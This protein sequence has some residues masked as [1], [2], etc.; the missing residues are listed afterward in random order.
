MACFPL[1]LCLSYTL[2]LTKKNKNNNNTSLI[3]KIQLPSLGNSPEWSHL[4]LW[5]ELH[6]WTLCLN[7]LFC[8]VQFSC[9]VV[10][11][12]LQPHGLQHT[13]LPC[14][15]PNSRSLLKHMSIESVITS[16]HLTVSSPSLP[17]FNLSQHQG[18]FQWVSSLHQVAKV[19]QLQL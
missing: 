1:I 13:R 14:P 10:S 5:I 12:A 9:S 11:N 16:N 19:L 2:L 18:L 3:F 4:H 15:S 6:R 17:A 7:T 8:S